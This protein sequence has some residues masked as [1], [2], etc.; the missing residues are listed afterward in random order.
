[1]AKQMCKREKGTFPSQPV[2]NPTKDGP[3]PHVQIN[4]IH[5]LR[6]W[7]KVDN[8][9]TLPIQ[10]PQ[11][12]LSLNQTKNSS[13]SQ[14]STPNQVVD[15]ESNTTAERTYEPPAPFP[16]PLKLKNNTVQMEQ[17]REIFK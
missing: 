11:P 4:A 15:K 3:A 17:M 12:P 10:E 14:L 16:N 13:E 5:T 1:M 9:V 2:A 8:H 6:S 7:K